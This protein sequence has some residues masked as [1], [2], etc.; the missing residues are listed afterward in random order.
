MKLL[1]RLSEPGA[2]EK[3]GPRSAVEGFFQH[4]ARIGEGPP[5]K[6]LVQAL[7]LEADA[8][9]CVAL[10]LAQRLVDAGV[11]AFE[12]MGTH[13]MLLVNANYRES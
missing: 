3:G 4:L 5:K 1:P 13:Q 7:P 9:G 8:H 11:N 12:P 2:G 10:P 6:L